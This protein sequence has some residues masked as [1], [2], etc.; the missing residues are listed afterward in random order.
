[1]SRTLNLVSEVKNAVRS[2]LRNN[3]S[4]DLSCIATKRDKYR[5][6]NI[7]S[8]RLEVT[9]ETGDGV[10]VF[11]ENQCQ[12]SDWE[13]ALLIRAGDPIRLKGFVDYKTDG[14]DILGQT[15][16]KVSPSNNGTALKDAI[17]SATQLSVARIK[18]DMA[19]S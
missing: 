13:K 12:P 2:D 18:A 3:L 10:A 7:T 5:R 19:S 8:I 14:A 1:M 16:R 11:R 4:V 6:Q 9:A 17:S 15:V